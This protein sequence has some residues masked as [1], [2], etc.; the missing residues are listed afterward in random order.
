MPTPVYLFLIPTCSCNEFYNPVYINKNLSILQVD[1]FIKTKTENHC[2][3][4]R[5]E[6]VISKGTR[7]QEKKIKDT[8]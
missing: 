1:C 6:M 2:Y 3:K 7:Q 4:V 5:I 8:L